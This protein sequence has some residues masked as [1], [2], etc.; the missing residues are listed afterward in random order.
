VSRQPRRQFIRTLA[1]GIGGAAAAS[2]AE[3]DGDPDVILRPPEEPGGIPTMW[4]GAVTHDSAT[5]KTKLPPGLR[6]QL[7][8]RKPGGAALLF[9][10]ITP[11]DPHSTV[12]TFHLSKL[13]PATRYLYTLEVNGQPATYPLGRLRTFPAAGRAADFRFAFSSCARTGSQHKVFSTIAGRDP[14]VFVHL[15]DLHYTNIS[16]NDPRLFRAAWDTVLSSKTQ[17]PLYRTVPLA[18]V[19]DDHDFGPND[20]DGRAP[21]RPASRRTY[22][23]YAPHYPLPADEIAPQAAGD[24]PIFQAFTL[25][26]ARFILTDLRSERTPGK[27]PDGPE[28]SMMGPGQKAWFLR[29]L[30]ESSRTHGIVFWGS[31][32]PW[33]GK[34]GGDSWQGYAAER[35]EISNFIAQHGIKNLCILCGDAHMLAADDGTHSDYSDTGG[36]RIPVLHGSALDQGGSV[37]GGPYSNGSHGSADKEGC[38]GWVEVQ[39]DGKHVQV[40]FTGRNQ[41]DKEILGLEFEM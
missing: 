7:R 18:Y 37:K 25:A 14:S 12:T 34:P 23:E 39:D 36:L 31:S 16:R 8:V 24:A 1:A 2:A 5:V 19:Y 9:D 3:T 6:A 4:L 22:R 30:L 32:L 27:I 10:A 26:R 35:R 13:E 33:I 15:G 41:D 21:G 29:E 17:G 11:S 20:A 28:K 38:F 40:A